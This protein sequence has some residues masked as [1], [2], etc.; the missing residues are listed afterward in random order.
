MFSDE[1]SDQNA[2]QPKQSEESESVGSEVNKGAA[3]E[4]MK[5]LA[6]KIYDTTPGINDCKFL[7]PRLSMISGTCARISFALTVTNL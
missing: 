6:Q 7:G 5:K 2:F 3:M 1:F 4:K